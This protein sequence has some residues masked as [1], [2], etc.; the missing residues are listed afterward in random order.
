MPWLRVFVAAFLVA[1]ALPWLAVRAP[2]AAELPLDVE[3]AA[4]VEILNTQ[5]VAAG[6]DPVLVS[7]TLTAAAE[8]MAQ[9]LAKIDDVSHTDTLGRGIRARFTFFGYPEQSSIRENVAAGYSTGASVMQGWND[10]PGHRANNLAADV[11]VVGI[12]RH[13][14]SGTKYRWFWVLTFGSVVDS[15]S[16]SLAEARG[17]VAGASS[18]GTTLPASGVALTT[19]PGG[20][21]EALR[22]AAL[23]S[24]VRAVYVFA[25]GRLVPYLLIAPDFVN[26]PFI[27]LWGGGPAPGTIILVV[28]D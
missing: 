6:L 1:S 24:N 14:E 23:S 7:P 15:G 22:Q 19:W 13:F 17:V 3:E 16:M 18:F 5:R 10:S 25:Q 20:S 28:I 27:D 21:L 9:D 11:R 26:Q 4:A 8:W 2:A 12:A